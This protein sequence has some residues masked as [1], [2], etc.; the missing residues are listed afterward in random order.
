MELSPW[1][2]VHTQ[3][4]PIHSYFHRHDARFNAMKMTGQWD[5]QHPW[6]ECFI[7]KTQLESLEE[8]LKTLPIHYAST[9]H[10]AAVAPCSPTG[11]LQLPKV[12]DIFA[13]MILNPGLPKPLIPSCLETI[14]NLDAFFLP[15]G[16]KRYLSGY[17]GDFLDREF[18]QNHFA[19]QYSDWVQLKQLYDP[20]NIFCSALHRH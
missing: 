7:Q 19:E 15:Q 6:Y 1:K 4:E 18:W 12:K 10:I 2:L 8:L 20:Q 5:L 14:K 11:F 9:V 13:F 17:L 3:D 16:G